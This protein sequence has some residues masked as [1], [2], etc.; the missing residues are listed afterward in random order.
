MYATLTG[1]TFLVLFSVI[2][3]STT[4]FMRHQIDDSV[5][6]EVD[7]IIADAPD[8]SVAAIERVVQALAQ[9]PSGFYYLLQDAN[10]IVRAGNLPALDPKEGIREWP[11]AAKGQG[12]AFS[13]VRGRGISLPGAYLFVGW[14]THQLLEM[15]E[16]VVRS[17]AWGLAASIA[18]ALAGGLVMSG[19]LMHR[20]E[21]V[22]QTSRDIIG[23]DCRNDCR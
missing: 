4:R 1:I 15:E 9:H 5:T 8:R 12:S 17:F 20:I 22:S 18:L 7:E 2:F 10:G 19:R 16:M 13:A 14:S 11:L 3:L 21:T 23:E 6:S